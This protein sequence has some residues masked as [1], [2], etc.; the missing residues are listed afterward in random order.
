MNT[1]NICEEIHN[2]IANLK[3]YKY[4]FDSKEFYKNGIY[5]LFEKDEKAHDTERIVRIG[6]HTGDDNL[7]VRLT[8]HFIKENKDRSIFRKNIG[9]AL[10]NKNQYS[11]LDIWNKDYTSSK[12]KLEYNKLSEFQKQNI[13]STEEEVSKYMRQFFSFAVIE[14]PEKSERLKYEAKLIGTI[15]NCQECKPSK[16]WL[17]HYATQIKIKESG[18]WLR[19]HLYK[20]Q[21]M[22]QEWKGFKNNYL[23]L[24]LKV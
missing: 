16:N 9:R 19:Q 2:T 5:I 23:V 1:E 13:R 10:I 6:T 14:I 17:G 15:S 4:P 8:E 7:R 20:N 3:R 12:N 24:N 11:Y 21:F 18:L 22:Y